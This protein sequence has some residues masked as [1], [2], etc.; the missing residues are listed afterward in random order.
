[1][2]RYADKLLAQGERIALRGRQHFLATLIEGRVAWAIFIA[3]LVLVLLVTQLAPD[4]PDIVRQLFSWLGLG[5]LLIGLAWLGADLPELVHAGLPDHEPARDEGRGHPQEALRR[6]LA[7][8]DQRRGP[9]AVGVRPDA[10]LRRPRH[11]DRERAVG[12]PLPDARAGADVQAHDARREAQAR[13]GRLP[14]PGAAAARDRAR[15]GAGA[16]SRLRR[17]SRRARRRAR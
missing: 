2:A 11:P 16:R 10:R 8:E 4:T 14:D 13:A 12:R 7:R 5:L 1:M 3:A 17:R 6:Q 15:P 9:R